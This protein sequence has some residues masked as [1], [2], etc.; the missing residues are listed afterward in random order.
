MRDERD[1]FGYMECP[2][3]ECVHY[4]PRYSWGV[5]VKGKI[6]KRKLNRGDCV[7]YGLVV[8]ATRIDDSGCYERD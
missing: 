8:S 3:G 6:E 5:A 7:R 4:V 2:C 1:Y